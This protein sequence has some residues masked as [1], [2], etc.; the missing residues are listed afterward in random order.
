MFDKYLTNGNSKMIAQFK[1]YPILE[2]DS[3]ILPFFNSV[4]RD[5]SMHELGIGTMHN[6]IMI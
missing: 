3:F 5:K 1:K 2:N 4:L 6:R